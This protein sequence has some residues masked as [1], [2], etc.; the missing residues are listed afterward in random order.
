MNLNEDQGA[1]RLTMPIKKSYE[2][3]DSDGE[4][5]MYIQG[6]ASGVGLDHHGERMAKSAIQAFAKAVSDGTYL[7]NG[8]LSLIPLRSGHRKEWDD[9]LGYVTKAEID[10]DYNL[11]IEAELDDSSSTARDLFKKLQRPPRSGRPLQLGLSVGG[12]IK[13][14]NYVWDETVKSR[15]K[16]IE[17][18][19]LREISVVGSP[20]YPTAYVEALEKSIN[21]DDISE[22]KTQESQMT[23]TDVKEQD[24][25]T[26]TVVTEDTT[27]TVTTSEQTDDVAKDAT[28]AQSITEPNESQDSEVKKT[29]EADAD[30]QTE[31]KEKVEGLEKAVGNLT[32]TLE[33]IKEQLSKSTEKETDATTEAK[34]DTVEKAFEDRLADVVTN[35]FAKFK[36]DN[37]DP[38]LSDVQA[39]KKSVEEIG[40]QEIDKSFA[41]RT[42]KEGEEALEKFRARIEKGEKSIIG[43]AVREAYVR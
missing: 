18:V 36:E 7:P 37:I 32:S 26:Q 38:L 21:W 16:T 35:A 8:D 17:D 43:A 24:E 3:I 25:A 40:S 14:A 11:W 10:D 22:D 2:R 5:H 29:A 39:V 20:A 19:L 34:A 27:K 23:K 41:V 9:I 30:P 31:L 4:S 15:V 1:F 12:K 33:A 6:L 13:K 28:T 42:A